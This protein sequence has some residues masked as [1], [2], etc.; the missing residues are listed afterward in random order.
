MSS[1][2]FIESLSTEDLCFY[3]KQEIPSLSEDVFKLLNEHKIDGGLFLELDDEYLKEVAPLLG[4]RLKL[5]RV[6]K[7]A[8]ANDVSSHYF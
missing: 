7:T 1:S 5:K 2:K 8:I 4:D 6:M 3:L